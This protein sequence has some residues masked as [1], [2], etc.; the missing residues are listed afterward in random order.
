MNISTLH[1]KICMQFQHIV[2]KKCKAKAEK[3]PISK[4]REVR[5]FMRYLE[6]SVVVKRAKNIHT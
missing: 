3:A 2:N 4:I 6:N 1:Y 5:A